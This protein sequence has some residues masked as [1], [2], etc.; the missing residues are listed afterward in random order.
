MNIKDLKALRSP[1]QGLCSACGAALL[2]VMA[3]FN[4][5]IAAVPQYEIRAA[6]THL[7]EVIAQPLLIVRE[8]ETARVHQGD[9]P[10]YTMGLLVRPHDED[11]VLLSLDFFSGR[12]QMQEDLVVPLDEPYQLVTEKL[13]IDLR[14]TRRETGLVAE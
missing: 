12:I 2:V 7:G 8:S 13:L 10:N 3:A 4:S 11:E 14:V 1:R 6:V 9:P 5:A